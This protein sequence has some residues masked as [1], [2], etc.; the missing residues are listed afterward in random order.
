MKKAFLVNGIL[1]LALAFLCVLQTPCTAG[2]FTPAQ[3]KKMGIFL[4]NFTELGFYNVDHR[5]FL[6]PLHP[7]MAIRFGIW[8][9]Y[10]NNFNSR[11]KHCRESCPYGSLTINGKYVA[12]SIDKYLG[13]SFDNHQSVSSDYITC[14]YDGRLY[15]FE[16][17]DGENNAYVRVREARS[18][19]DG[20]IRL[21]GEM[22]DPDDPSET[23]GTCN[24]EITPSSWQGKPSWNL[25]NISCNRN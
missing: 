9:N 14:H 18:I 1:G 10:R 12:E 7:E 17:A 25:L 2:D 11:I 6:D 4:S 23:L 15:H 3:I 16:G 8:H 20:V 5:D 13:F 22:Y 21:R 19:S 24:A